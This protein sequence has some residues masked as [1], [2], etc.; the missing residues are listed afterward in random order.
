MR[1][2]KRE[3]EALPVLFRSF[4]HELKA[5]APGREVWYQPSTGMV[6]IQDRQVDGSWAQTDQYVA[7]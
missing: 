4:M 3:I 2:T 1:Y 5:Q 7:Q 6:T